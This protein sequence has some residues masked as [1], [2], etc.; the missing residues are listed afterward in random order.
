MRHLPRVLNRFLLFLLGLIL[1]AIGTAVALLPILPNFRKMWTKYAGIAWDWYQVN[2]DQYRINEQV[3]WL[4]VAWLA[5][6]A[7][8]IIFMLVWIFKQ[9][10][11]RTDEVASLQSESTSGHVTAEVNFVNEVLQTT[12]DDDRFI[13][14]IS[15]SAWRVKREPGIRVKVIAAKGA[16]VGEVH[17]SVSAAVKR[18]DSVFGKTVPVLVHVTSGWMQKTPARTD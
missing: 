2:A 16:D 6:A 10:G 9:G 3:S 12:L 14:S 1:I 4:Q 15:T 17:D 5:I 11:G 7:L 8:I 13:S 18:M